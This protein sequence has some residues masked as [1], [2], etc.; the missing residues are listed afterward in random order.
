MVWSIDAILCLSSTTDVPSTPLPPPDAPTQKPRFP[1]FRP[2]CSCV[3]SGQRASSFSAVPPTFPCIFPVSH[4]DIQ[5]D[6]MNRVIGFP[7]MSGIHVVS[8]SHVPLSYRSTISPTRSL[9]QARVEMAEMIA[10]LAS[11]SC[12]KRSHE[13]LGAPARCT[14]TNSVAALSIATGLSIGLVEL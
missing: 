8:P 9:L 1:P 7:S 3:R 5:R 13:A 10:V 14:P 2:P 11:P 6:V 12:R 4:R